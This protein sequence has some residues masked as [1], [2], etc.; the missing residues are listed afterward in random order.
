M[1]RGLATATD[2]ARAIA[3][4]LAATQA[5]GAPAVVTRPSRETAPALPRPVTTAPA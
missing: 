5:V 3:G 2:A 4:A 1:L